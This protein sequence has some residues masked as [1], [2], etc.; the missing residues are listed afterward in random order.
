MYDVQFM[1]VRRDRDTRDRGALDS[2]GNSVHARYTYCTACLASTVVRS[3]MTMNI[4]VRTCRRVAH[5]LIWPTRVKNF[6]Y[7]PI[8]LLHERVYIRTWGHPVLI[9]S[10]GQCWSP[11]MSC[12]VVC[13]L[14]RCPRTIYAMQMHTLLACLGP[15]TH[16]VVA[17]S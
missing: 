17:R 2:R 15:R 9:T 6:S 12:V 11:L 4:R 3:Y 1:Q 16:V 7:A 8:V 5:V 14:F 13:L 10:P